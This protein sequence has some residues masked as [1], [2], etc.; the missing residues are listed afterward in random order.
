MPQSSVA[1]VVAFAGLIG[2]G[3][4]PT[5]KISA[6]NAEGTA[7]PYGIAVT[8]AATQ[9]H[10]DIDEIEEF[11]AAADIILGVTARSH[12]HATDTLSGDDAIADNA[13]CALVK[14]GP[15]YVTVEEAVVK[16]D[17]VFVRFTSDGGSNT[18]LGG[19]RKSVDTNR[20]RRLRGAKYMTTAASGGLA[21]VMLNCDE[22]ESPSEVMFTYTEN[23]E[24]TADATRQIA[25]VPADRTL[26]ITK[27]S[28]RNVTGL[29][30]NASNY[31]NI[32]VQHGAGPTVALNIS[33][34]TVA[35]G[36]DAEVAMVAGTLAN[37]TVPP[38]TKID[39]FFDET[40]VATL[41]T[42]TVVTVYGYLL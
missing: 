33:T 5:S 11:D 26:V 20:A 3:D 28:I 1:D 27:G 24:L 22:E 40:G 37:R 38:G 16:G 12:E 34:E 32:K 9:N 19:F 14:K 42:G 23:N 7:I 2:Y 35:L 30:V 10:D 36:A 8:R 18:Q 6:K 13:T 4:F 39:L 15:V 17:E 41:P 29:A 21:L 31:F 25:G